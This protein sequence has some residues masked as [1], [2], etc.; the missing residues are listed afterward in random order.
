MTAGRRDRRAGGLV[1]C[2]IGTPCD[3]PPPAVIDAL[4]SSGTERG[5][6]ASAGSAGLPPGRRRVAAPTIR[7]RG[8]PG[9]RAGRLCGHQGVRGLDRPVPPSA[10]TRTGTPCC[11]RP[12]PIPPTPWGPAR[13]VPA[14]AGARAARRRASTSPPIDA[15]RRRPGPDAVGQLA[16]PTRPGSSPTWRRRPGGVGPRGSPCSPT[17][18]TPSSPGT[19]RPARSSTAGHRRRGG[20]AL[21]V[22]AVQPG[23]GA[24]R[25]LRRRP[26]AGRLPP[27]RAPARRA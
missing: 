15:G 3:P 17:S 4:A 1:D 22:Q 27:R 20:R 18:A 2:S 9:P 11:T 7:G 24:G 12:S 10:L 13:R 14:G 19:A 21:P 25:V 5:Y 8:R 6:P 23:R 26:R 16:R